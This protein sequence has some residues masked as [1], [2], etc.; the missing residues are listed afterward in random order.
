MVKLKR[1]LSLF[2]T[3]MTI[4]ACGVLHAAD[5]TV[6]TLKGNIKASPCVVDNATQTVELGDY[7]MDSTS[8]YASWVNFELTLSSCPSGTSTVTATF[9]GK[10]GTDATYFY[11]NSGTAKGV[12]IE[13]A[14][15]GGNGKGNGKQMDASVTEGGG[16]T[17]LLRA[18]IAVSDRSALAVGTVNTAVTVT[19]TYS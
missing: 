14:D 13:L 6:I 15:R 7:Y 5:T 1:V 12:D 11:A 4:V 16:A 19:F 3:S 8:T 9:S 10:D 17:F 18:R 2:L